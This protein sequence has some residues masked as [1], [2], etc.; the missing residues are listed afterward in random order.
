VVDGREPHA[1][2]LVTRLDAEPYAAALA[3]ARDIVARSPDAIRAAKRLYEAA[4]PARA[5]ERLA[6]ESELQRSLI[7]TPN[8]LAS[9]VAGAE[10]APAAFVDPAVPARG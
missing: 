8:Q 1:L 6:L 5:A 4:W 3:L 7:G 9:V 2:G 10:P